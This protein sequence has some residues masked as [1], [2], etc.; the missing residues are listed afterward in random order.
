MKIIFPETAFEKF[1]GMTGLIIL[2]LAACSNRLHAP[3]MVPYVM[4]KTQYVIHNNYIHD[5]IIVKKKLYS[6]DKIFRERLNKL[7]ERSDVAFN[8]INEIKQLNIDWQR[9]YMILLDRA[10]NT[11]QE[12]DSLYTVVKEMDKKQDSSI[13]IA[14]KYYTESQQWKVYYQQ[15]STASK[16]I[17]WQNYIAFG[18][19]VI[20]LFVNAFLSNK[21][22][23][24][25]KNLTYL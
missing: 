18:I 21:I 11:R 17:N 15:Y 20:L 3:A 5:T 23:K 8:D 9:N 14:N 19:I 24:Q 25:Q 16:S 6:D 4:P 12:K 2:F 13:R 22:R 1:F 10:R 7:M